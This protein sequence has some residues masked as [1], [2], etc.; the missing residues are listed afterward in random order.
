MFAILGVPRVSH[1]PFRT[2]GFSSINHPSG[3][4]PIDGNPHYHQVLTIISQVLTIMN[5]M[6]I[7]N[8]MCSHSFPI[9]SHIFLY[10]PFVFLCCPHICYLKTGNSGSVVLPVLLRRVCSVCRLWFFCTEAHLLGFSHR[11]R[12]FHKKK[13]WCSY[14]YSDR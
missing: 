1:H 9:F 6:F 13:C 12:E 5:Y 7:I 8:H 10:L 14:M 3:G 11:R 2:M 4:T